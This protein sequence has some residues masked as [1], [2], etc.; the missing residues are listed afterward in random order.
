[1][2]KPKVASSNAA[3]RSATLKSVTVTEF[4]P[5][6]PAVLERFSEQ[7]VGTPVVDQG[8]FGTVP[9]GSASQFEDKTAKWIWTSPNARFSAPV[10]SYNFAAQLKIMSVTPVTAM[11]HILVDNDA[12][13]YLNGEKVGSASL[14]FS[15]RDYSRIPLT[16]VWGVNDIVLRCT[17]TGVGPAGVCASLIDD[18]S[19]TPLL[20][21]E[22]SRWVYNKV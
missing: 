8:G 21:T 6:K 10:G 5:S 12:D 13:I 4:V 2:F 9:W 15:A 1:M 16:L 7:P 17:N 22:G 18:V 11:L 3:S 20:K 19:K 14:G